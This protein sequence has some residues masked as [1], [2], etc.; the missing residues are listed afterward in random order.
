MTKINGIQFAAGL[1]ADFTDEIDE[2]QEMLE[3]YN[4]TENEELIDQM[5]RRFRHL[6]S[7]LNGVSYTINYME[8]GEDKDN[9]LE[10]VEKQWR[11]W[12]YGSF[13]MPVLQLRWT[14]KLGQPVKVQTIRNADGTETYSCQVGE[15]QTSGRKH[16]EEIADFLRTLEA[17][18]A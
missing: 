6:D 13:W 2:L 16:R 18:A 5:V 17:L 3:E 7:F 8:D 10:L 11:G 1:S 15:N 14:K 4:A 12:L 9:L